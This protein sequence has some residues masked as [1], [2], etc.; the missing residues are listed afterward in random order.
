MNEEQMR[1]ALE[2]VAISSDSALTLGQVRAIKSIRARAIE[3]VLPFAC[4]SQHDDLRDRMCTAADMDLNIDISTKID[5]HLVQAGLTV[6]PNV[7]NVI[8]V[9]SGKGGVGKSTTAVNIALALA[10]EGARVGLLDADI[11]G[12]SVPLL[13]QL[14][15]KPELN[16]DEKMVP[17]ARYG[18]QASSIGFLIDSDSPMAWRGPMVSQALQQLFGQ[19]A[20]DNLDYLIIDMPPGTGDIQL[21]LSQKI[22]VTGAV[23]VTTPQ[24][25]ALLDARKGLK[26][27]EKTNIPVL[28]VVENMALHTCSNCGHEEAIFGAGGAAKMSTDFDVPLLGQLPLAM[29]IRVQADRG[30][31]T[32]AANPNSV[33]AQHYRSIARKIG[34][35]LAVL[36]KDLSHKFKVTAG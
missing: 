35:A 17:P 30:Q 11:Y 20:W 21:T 16:A 14:E 31:P 26:M 8:A 29:D 1:A 5:A 18:V 15:G 34:A 28:G 19:T 12:P 9:A 10:H 33:H 22:P 2:A 36:P 25:L 6:A 4:A 27:F 23:I 7:K 32:V 24:D 13:L 3:V